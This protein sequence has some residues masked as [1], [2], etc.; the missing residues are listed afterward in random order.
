MRVIEVSKRLCGKVVVPACLHGGHPLPETRKRKCVVAD[1]ADV[2]LGLPDA[3]ALDARARV[4][5]VDHTP[6]EEVV[7]GRRCGKR[8]IACGRLAEQKPEPWPGGTKL[9]RR[10]HRE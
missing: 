7:R 10:G 3:P 4:E 8:G 6:P 2:M 5:R 1:G 9:S